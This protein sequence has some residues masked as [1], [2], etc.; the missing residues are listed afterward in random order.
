MRATTGALLLTARS[1]EVATVVLPKEEVTEPVASAVVVVTVAVEGR[2][3]PEAR[4][5][6]T[7]ATIEIVAE[8]PG[9][10]DAMVSVIV[11]PLLLNVKLGPP[12]CDCEK[13]ERP[14]GTL[15]VMLTLAA[16]EGP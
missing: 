1:A 13:Y 10:S 5:A 15:S 3:A 9:A 6:G 11:L 2:L 4:L 7:V 8:A 12:T 16:A 14:D